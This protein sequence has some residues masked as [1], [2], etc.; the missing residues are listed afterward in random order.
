MTK[1]EIKRLQE[2]KDEDIDYSDIPEL[3]DEEL[4][5]FRPARDSLKDI[6]RR[7]RAALARMICDEKG[8]SDLAIAAAE[9]F[10][11]RTLPREPRPAEAI[12]SEFVEISI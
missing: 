1:D 3:T 11:A 9:A 7:N 6:A 5:S 8:S 12:R 2:M 4:K 10:V